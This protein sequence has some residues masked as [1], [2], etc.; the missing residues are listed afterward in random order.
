MEITKRITRGRGDKI[1]KIFKMKLKNK[2]LIEISRI[3]KARDSR[4]LA[5][6]NNIDRKTRCV[7]QRVI[8][9]QKS[10][11]WKIVVKAK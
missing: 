1:S 9:V 8:S 11:N 4:V 10:I 7:R 6:K 2:I 3:F 5:R